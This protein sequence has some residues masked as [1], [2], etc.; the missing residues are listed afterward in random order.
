MI[1]RPR[2]FGLL[3]LCLVFT[4]CASKRPLEPR[5]LP[6]RVAIVP[7]EAP[8]IGSVS[9]GE[10]PGTETEMR[11]DLSCEEITASLGEALEK[12]CFASVT[13]IG[14][15]DDELAGDAFARQRAVLDRAREENVD[16]IIEF[17]LRYDA[18]IYRKKAS[19]FWLNY[20]LFLFAGPSNWFIGDNVY[21]ADVD[22]TTNVYD[23][24]VIDAG[25]FALGDPGARVVTASSRY[26]GADL[27]FVD[28]SDGMG[29]YA[30]GI[31][32]PSGF[33]S[34]E[35]D[36]TAQ[37]I[38]DAIVEELRAQVVQGIQS[39]RGDLVRAEWIAPVHIEPEEVHMV[40]EGDELVLSGS[41]RIRRDSLVDRVHVLHLEV[42]GERVSVYPEVNEELRTELH[43]V[44]PFSARIPL[45][46]DANELH[47]ECEA[48]ARDRYVRSYTYVLPKSE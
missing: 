45:S 3:A 42:G 8:L 44:A 46:A 21:F 30:L 26:T 35:S 29:D 41:V 22:L 24:N 43:H 7:M 28:R 5:T 31:L 15:D 17:G 32:I 40:R 38:H 13:I 18:E 10:L 25:G 4:A 19:S 33:L 48:G 20:P 16:L 12:Y 9:P 6:Y 27:D 37:H 14:C 34:R 23:M 36:E 11:L 47:M 1:I 39:R 2:A